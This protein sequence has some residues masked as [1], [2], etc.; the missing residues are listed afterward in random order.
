MGIAAEGHLD[1]EALRER[2]A[3]IEDRLHRALLTGLES[4]QVRVINGTA[5]FKDP[6][7]IVVETDGGLEE[8]SAD[9]VAICT[10]SRPRVPISSRRP[11][12]CAHHP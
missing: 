10:G 1:V 2:V 7:T 3:S 11:R 5:R 6:H 9:F 4:Q 8:I 12:A